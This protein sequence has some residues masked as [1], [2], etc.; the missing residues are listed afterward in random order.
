MARFRLIVGVAGLALL[1]L[2]TTDPGQHS[3]EN[4]FAPWNGIWQGEFVAYGAD[5]EIRYRMR[6]EQKYT[7]IGMDLQRGVFVNRVAGKEAET[8]HAVNTVEDGKLFCRVRSIDNKGKAIGPVR[9]HQGRLV[10]PGHIFWYSDLGDGKF[11][12]FNERVDGTSYTIHGV[13]VYGPHPED[14]HL[15]E[16]RYTRK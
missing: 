3:S 4:P 6:V 5:G 16:A 14:R 8:V 13:G 9:E 7:Q 15:F 2:T 12:S 1:I 10:G 11:E